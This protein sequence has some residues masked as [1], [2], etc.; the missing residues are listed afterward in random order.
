MLNDAK[1]LTVALVAIGGGAIGVDQRY[2]PRSEV[3]SLKAEQRVQAIL[4]LKD[5]AQ[6][7]G[8]ETWLCRAIEEQFVLLCNELPDHYLCRDPEAKRDIMQKSGC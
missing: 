7:D 4:N 2:A 5:Q 8:A 3:T 1:G 6:R